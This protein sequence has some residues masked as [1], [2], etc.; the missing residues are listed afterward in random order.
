M[1][2]IRSSENVTKLKHS[3]TAATNEN[4]IHEGN[5]G[6]LGERMLKFTLQPFCYSPAMMKYE[7]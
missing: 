7:D 2:V 1:A 6:R 3:A 5:T 4:C